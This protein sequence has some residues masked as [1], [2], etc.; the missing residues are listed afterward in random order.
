MLS[1]LRDFGGRIYI[2]DVLILFTFK[3]YVRRRSGSKSFRM[4]LYTRSS[5]DFV[6]NIAETR[7]CQRLFYRGC[8][9]VRLVRLAVKRARSAA[10]Q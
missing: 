7:V 9:V 4:L 10:R 1:Y 3:A 6:G 8:L 2:L 5:A